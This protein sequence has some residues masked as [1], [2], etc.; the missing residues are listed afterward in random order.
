MIFTM[1]VA[2]FVLHGGDPLAVKELAAVC[3]AVF[4]LMYIA[5]SGGY[6]LDRLIA[7]GLCE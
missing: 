2:L 5:D 4:V 1:R 3:L 6:A 7:E